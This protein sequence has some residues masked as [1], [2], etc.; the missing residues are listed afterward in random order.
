MNHIEIRVYGRNGLV[1]NPLNHRDRPDGV[2]FRA[3]QTNSESARRVLRGGSFNNQP[4]NV[5]SANRNNNLPTNRNNNNGF[6][7]ASTL[8]LPEDVTGATSVIR[9]DYLAAV[10][11]ADSGDCVPLIDLHRKYG[12]RS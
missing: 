7:L 10:R 2:E 11:A 6:H 1:Q 9:D 5:R 3:I 8:P 12:A 4:S